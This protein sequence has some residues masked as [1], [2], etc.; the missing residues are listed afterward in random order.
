MR[1][2]IAAFLRCLPLDVLRPHWPHEGHAFAVLDQERVA[3]L[4]PAARHAGVKPGMRRAG[5]AAIAPQVELLPRQPQ[6][7][8]DVLH[9]AALALLQYTPEIALGDADTVLLNVGASLMFFGGP[10]ALSQRIRATLR[11]L[12][13][14]VSLGMAPTARG[15]W[16]LAHRAGRRMPRR[17]VTLPTLA[18]RLDALPLALLPQAQARL[19]WLGDIGCHTLADLRALPRAGLQRR[20]TPDLLQAMDA[21]YGQAPELYRWIEPPNQF[22]R[23]IE[24]MDYVEHTD[25]VLAVARRL[26]EQLGGWLTA[27]QLAVRRVVLSLEHERGRHARPPTEL[28]LALAQ[29]VWQAPQILHLLREKLNHVTLEAPVIA[30]SL[31]A[32]DT[33]EQPAVSTTLFPEPGGTAADHARLLDLLVARLG[34]DQVRH[35]QPTPDHRPEAANSWGD[36]LAAPRPPAPLPPLLDRP[37]WLLKTPLALKLSGHRP[38]YGGQPLRLVR[39][40]ERIESGWWDPALTV[41]DYFVAEDAAAARYWIYR[42]RDAEHAR[43]FLHG[44]YA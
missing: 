18:R 4:T 21:A 24:L 39:G 15:A 28:E 1:L 30:V 20:S 6:A 23:R 19:D 17:T 3:A 43:W 9:G 33:V 37:F 14:R 44:L 7:E 36:A 16:L 22:S 5:A 42:E 8:T 26:A 12:D 32:P 27:R 13:L 35:A 38:Q 29:P 34:R 11:A 25:A 41:R 31:L 40:P 2:W 10:R